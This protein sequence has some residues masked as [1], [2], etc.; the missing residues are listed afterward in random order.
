MPGPREIEVFAEH[1]RDLKDRTGHSYGALAGRLHVGRSTLH[2]Y[3]LGE[4][5]PVD[6]AVVERL[7]RL[8]GAPREEL[9]ELHRQWVLATEA[10]QN[11]SEQQRAPEPPPEPAPEPAPEPEPEPTPEEPTPEPEPNPEDPED[12]EPA[13]EHTPRQRP[14]TRL[15]LTVAAVTTAAALAAGAL[16]AAD[17]TAHRPTPRPT[18]GEPAPGEPAPSEP[19]PPTWTADAHV[20]ANGC[21]HRYLV[22]RAPEAVPPP[23]VEQDARDWASRLGAVHGGRTIVRATV[24]APAGGSA[25]VERLS[26]RVVAR[27][28]PLNWPSYAMSDGCGGMLT[29]AYYAVDLD[30]ARP[31]ACP[32]EGSDSERALPVTRLPYRVSEGDPLVVRV[33]AT[34]TRCDC[35]WYLEADWSAGGRRG[36][37]R[38]DDAGKPF[39]TSGSSPQKIHTYT[40]EENNWSR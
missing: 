22:D 28:P 27:R 38:I 40:Q 10:R 36:T 21:D 37:L 26:V 23:P 12:P 25:V 29:P 32:T 18:P 8:A 9:L 3:C 6:Y 31:L 35:D 14:R 24:S 2:R 5:V 33:E 16:L 13:P 19:A 17:L 15:R 4:T 34:A 7:A 11:P 20:W 1:L 39:R 30:A